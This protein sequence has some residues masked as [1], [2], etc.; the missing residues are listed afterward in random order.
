ML[1][2]CQNDVRALMAA[3]GA[4]V[5]NLS[6]EVAPSPVP[7]PEPVIV[8]K[9]DDSLVFKAFDGTAEAFPGS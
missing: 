4:K 7:V 5:Y 6:A 8:V 9:P 3:R 1:L 2:T